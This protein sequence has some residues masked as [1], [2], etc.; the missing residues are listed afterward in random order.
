MD[1]AAV[2]QVA[3]AVGQLMAIAPQIAEIDINPLV[4]LPRGEGAVALDA[5]IVIGAT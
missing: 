1:L 4:V 3:T 5:L 2:A